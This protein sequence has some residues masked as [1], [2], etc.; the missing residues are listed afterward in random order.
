MKEVAMKM[1]ERA[2]E[3]LASGAVARVVAWKKGDF[4]FDPSPAVFETVEELEA[5][6]VYDYFCGAN[7]SKYLIEIS[8]KA[9]KT[10]VFLKPCDTYSF[11]QLVKEHRVNRENIHVIAVECLGKLDI[12]KIK[13]KG[14]VGVT[15]VEVLDQEVK[16]V[17]AYGEDTLCKKEIVLTKC[18]TCNKTKRLFC[19]NAPKRT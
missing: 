11:N 2:K 4:C 15:G 19:T 5:S 9:G 7:L 10:A 3:L 13:A 6:F 17:S 8:K 18:A 1:L 16:V 14:V 12:E